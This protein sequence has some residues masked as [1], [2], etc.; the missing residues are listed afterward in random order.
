MYTKHLQK[1]VDSIEKQ[2]LY[3]VA[4]PIGNLADITLRALAVLQKADIICAED[5]RVTAQLLS[6]Y[7]IQG[8]LV[9]VREHNE[10][11]MADKIIAH[12][13]DGLSVAQVSDAGTPAVCDPGAKLAA[14]VREAGF[15]VVP[16]VG[17]SAVMGALSVAGVTESD[18]YFNGFLPPKAGERQKLL[19]KW[20]EAD[21]PIVM[22]E[23]PHR[24]EASLADM[25][26][27]FPERRLTLAREITKTF[28]TF[29]SGTVAEIQAALK[30]DSNQTRGEM[31]LVL[32]PA[33]KEKHSDLPEAAQNTMKIL[34]AELPTKQAAEL[35]AKITGENK[36]ALYDLALEWKKQG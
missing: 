28:E 10:Q 25:V 36:K 13:S 15:K 20:A 7:G 26:A 14:R 18:F 32:H 19:A 30:N 22:F 17:A 31:V 33:V 16:V 1:A 9:S 5:T 4:T 8:K 3:V 2:T 21:F 24:I 6:A 11:Q 12:L 23:T 27:Q 29:L 34:A 35:A